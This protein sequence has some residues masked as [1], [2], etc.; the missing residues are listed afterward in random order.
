MPAGAAASEHEGRLPRKQKNAT[1]SRQHYCHECGKCFAQSSGLTKYR[2]ILPGRNHT[3]VKTVASP[4]SGVLPSSSIRESTLMRNHMS[5]RTRAWSSVTVQTLSDTRE[6]TQGSVRSVGKPSAR[7]AASLNITNSTQ[8]RSHT[9]GAGVAKF[10]LP[11]E[12]PEDP[13]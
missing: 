12:T 2:R 4:T 1:G 8:E 11:P 6:P 13:W 3:N 10:L 9:S 5:V 7:T